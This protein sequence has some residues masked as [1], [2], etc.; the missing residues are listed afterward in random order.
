MSRKKPRR[1]D[2]LATA[3]D[4]LKKAIAAYCV[5]QGTNLSV[6][7]REMLDSLAVDG[8]AAGAFAVFDVDDR[9]ISLILDACVQARELARDFNKWC[10]DERLALA[11]MDK[12]DRAVRDLR[13]FVEELAQGPRNKLAAWVHHDPA[14]WQAIQHGLDTIGDDIAARRRIAHETLPRIGAGRKLADVSE[15]KAIGWLA[16]GVERITGKPHTQHVAALATIVLGFDKDNPCTPSRVIKARRSLE[17][18][19]RLP[20]R[21]AHDTRG[22]R[23]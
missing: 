7:D 12:L 14:G 5:A 17:R 18:Q 2:Q 15:T 4:R 23:I 6:S 22:K 8:V 20:L 9:E 19:W 1:T 13:G 11:R 3:E 16:K 10:K 21:A